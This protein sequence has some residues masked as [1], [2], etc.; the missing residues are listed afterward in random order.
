ME[1]SPLVCQNF[2]REVRVVKSPLKR[3]LEEL[4][5]RN[6]KV[7]HFKVSTDYETGERTIIIRTPS[8][9][10]VRYSTKLENQLQETLL[11]DFKN[12]DLIIIPIGKVKRKNKRFQKTTKTF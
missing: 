9:S 6:V 10:S 8:I 2:K 11:K 12:W 4:R 3:V 1:K 7:K 5:K